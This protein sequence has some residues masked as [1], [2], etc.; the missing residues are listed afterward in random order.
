MLERLDYTELNRLYSPYGR[1]SKLPPQD[2]LKIVIYA[3]LEGTYSLRGIQHQCKVNIEYMWLLQGR[4][5][6]SH[7]A[8]GRFFKRVPVEVWEDIFAQLVH[9]IGE[10]DALPLQEVYIDGT[11]LEASANRYTFVWKKSVVKNRARLMEKIDALKERCLSDGYGDADTSIEGLTKLLEE[12]CKKQGVQMVSGKGHHKQ[13]LQR[14]TEE[15]RGYRDKLQ[16]YD[17]MYVIQ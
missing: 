2:M 7:M 5:A 16:E 15:S 9:A 12:E 17:N 4:P 8:I 11:K 1:K 6:P 14:L 13:P 10:M 3:M